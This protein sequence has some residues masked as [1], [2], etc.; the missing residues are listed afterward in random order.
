SPLRLMDLARCFFPLHS[1]R[2]LQIRYSSHDDVIPP[3]EL[4]ALME[5][6]PQTLRHLCVQS[7]S[8]FRS[9]EAELE[10]QIKEEAE[11]MWWAAERFHGQGTRCGEERKL[12]L[13]A[14]EW[15][16]SINSYENFF[17]ESGSGKFA[18]ASM[19]QRTRRW[20]V[21]R[22]APMSAGSVRQ[23][24][25]THSDPSEELWGDGEGTDNACT[26]FPIFETEGYFKEWLKSYRI[27]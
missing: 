14:H 10:A 7:A 13:Q 21:V 26:R 12:F 16:K 15:D 19:T 11:A 8:G 25:N 22:L 17:R 3:G 27:S 5:Q 2:C 18:L 23:S 9:T 6:V 1:L 4:K 20:D 24:L